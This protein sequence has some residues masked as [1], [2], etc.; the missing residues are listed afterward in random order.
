MISNSAAGP[1]T[2]LW[3]LGVIAY[4]F[5]TGQQPFK[6]SNRNEVF[7]K[8]QNHDYNYPADIDTDGRDLIEQL[9]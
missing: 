4:E 2:D 1:F 5:M 3:A 9:L 6:G 7:E 8:I